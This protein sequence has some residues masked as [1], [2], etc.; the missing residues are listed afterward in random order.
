MLRSRSLLVTRKES[1]QDAVI[2]SHQLLS[3][4]GMF[5]SSTS[6]GLWETLPSGLRTL[7]K[8]IHEID[9]EMQLTL[10]AQKLEMPSL[11][12]SEVWKKTKRWES[13]GREMFK[14]KDRKKDDLALCPT[15]EEL[16][17]E[18]VG[19]TYGSIPKAVLPLLLYQTGRKFRDE[20]RPR[21]GLLRAREFVM[22]DLYSFH[23][24]ERC[25]ME[26]YE[27]VC[28]AY[29]N[30]FN[31]RLGV[32]VIKAE[33]D[34]ASMGGK[35]SHEFH[36]ESEIGEDSILKCDTGSFAA[37]SEAAFY[38][39]TAEN[40][41]DAATELIEQLGCK[42]RV[43]IGRVAIPQ[44][45][46]RFRDTASPGDVLDAIKLNI[47]QAKTGDKCSHKNC[48]CQG[49]GIL[50]E[51]KCIEVGHAF[52]L[53]TF[54]SKALNVRADVVDP[55]DGLKKLLPVQ[56]GSY[57][58]GVTR[59]IAALAEINHDELGLVWPEAI[60]PFRVVLVGAPSGDASLISETFDALKKK[61]GMDVLY[62]DR[63]NVG[64]SA[65]MYDAKLMGIPYMCVVG[66][67][68][69]ELHRRVKGEKKADAVKNVRLVK[70]V[71]ELCE[72]V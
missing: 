12:G 60:A 40:L 2:S 68:G 52:F 70:S 20:A 42:V 31:K 32:K 25:A 29:E 22:K 5:R 65:K 69:L 24:S 72:L 43:P 63:E 58:L 47:V 8:L 49:R 10:S 45:V 14:F 44:L 36:F 35:S 4:S 50:R 33:A 19:K 13:F 27:N 64:L 54:Y 26:T 46:E 9:M 18:L 15:H 62:D 61:Y 71:T 30:L 16:F 53:G 41:T 21:A 59:I 17:T 11:T 7:T 3:R 51:T 55:A 37:N 39:V 56:M 57:G 38:S 67:Q 1:P 34:S 66:K 28:G 6:S 48:T 23:A